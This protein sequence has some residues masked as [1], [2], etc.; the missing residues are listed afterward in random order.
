LRQQA[1]ATED[2]G[3]AEPVILFGTASASSGEVQP[4]GSI[5]EFIIYETLL[6]E[7]QITRIES[8][9]AVKYGITLEKSYLNSAG[10]TI[11]DRKKDEVY[12]HNIAG[13]GRD[14][15]TL[16][17]QKQSTSNTA[18]DQ[19]TV[20]VNSIAKDNASNV[21]QLNDGDYLIWGDNGQPFVPEL[22]TP[23]SDVVLSQKKWLMNLSGKTAGTFAT[24]VEI[25]TKKL[26]PVDFSKEYFCLVID[27]SGSG[28]F[29]PKD[30]NY[31]MPTSISADGIA[32][33]R[34][35]QWAANGS[36]RI[37][38][39]FGLKTRLAADISLHLH[40]V[41][42]KTASGQAN[43][44]LPGTI[45][46]AAGVYIVKLFADNKEYSQILIRP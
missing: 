19:L 11:W 1:H 40:L 36:R 38:F 27:R 31:F 37:A 39:T 15:N 35:I 26:V 42:S 29:A 8:Y 41:D 30:C 3:N 45:N 4:R 18:D 44:I 14:D 5:A 34:N 13:I 33:F 22:N 10:K 2:A 16:L 6:T 23:G 43:Y 12:S 9:L 7:K 20:A 17:Y 28:S 46:A 25:D 21:S 32:S 24:E